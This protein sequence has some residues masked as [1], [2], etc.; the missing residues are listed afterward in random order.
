MKKV[1]ILTIV[2]VLLGCLFVTI[3][4]R[5]D[6]GWDS[7]YDSG[8]SSSDSGS[9]FSGGGSSGYDYDGYTSDV[10]MDFSVFD[11][12]IMEAF[13]S[14]HFLLFCILPFCQAVFKNNVKRM[15]IL[16]MALRIGILLF[17]DFC[18]TPNVAMVDF[19]ALFVLAAFNMI[20][21]VKKGD[22]KVAD[23]FN[24]IFVTSPEISSE[25]LAGFGIN[26]REALKQEF[27][28]KYV[29]IQNAWM[30]FDYDALQNLCTDELYNTYKSQL[31]VL[32][33][34]NGQNIMSDYKL[35]QAKVVAVRDENNQL[36]V[37]VMMKISLFDYVI[38]AN[39]GEVRRGNKNKKLKNNY[40]M[41][42]VKSSIDT[43]NVI[44]CPNCNSEVHVNASGE[45]EYCGTVIVKSSKEFVLAKK[46]NT[47]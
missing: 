11:A 10:T 18:V 6:S 1:L 35:E 45:C 15:A 44:H 14:I 2:F 29:D 25:T 30:N 12:I 43:N 5:A 22:N 37:T 33:L 46:E 23:E 36:S 42:F 13:V 17:L 7:S 24:N 47:N 40:V 16:L 39:T 26:D 31:D 3:P 28:Q 9:S 19:V 21:L 32:K 27:F 34:K 20:F 41:T 8:G 38:D 4:V